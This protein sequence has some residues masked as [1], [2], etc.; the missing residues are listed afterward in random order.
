[1]PG[2]AASGAPLPLL[3]FPAGAAA[4]PRPEC[5]CQV[6]RTG[7]K[8]N[9]ENKSPHIRKRR[10]F[11]PGKH[12]W[13]HGPA[14]CPRSGEAAGPPCDTAPRGD[15][16]QP[17]S[18]PASPAVNP[19]ICAA[20]SAAALDSLRSP[21]RFSAAAPRAHRALPA[22]PCPP[23]SGHHPRRCQGCSGGHRHRR[24]PEGS[25]APRC[26]L[27]PPALPFAVVAVASQPSWLR[28]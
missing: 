5:G 8:R 17:E 19:F 27:V 24:S 14:V 2:G 23:W 3:P 7:E 21:L 13:Q 25:A 10:G 26:P 1:M 9:K 20:D 15:P 22:P 4:K 6:G 11:P 12:L 16:A 28:D 18:L